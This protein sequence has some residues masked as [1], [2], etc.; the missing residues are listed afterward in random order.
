MFSPLS[1]LGSSESH[2]VLMFAQISQWTIV[3]LRL[4]HRHQMVM[5]DSLCGAHGPVARESVGVLFCDKRRLPTPGS[6]HDI[7]VHLPTVTITDTMN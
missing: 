3:R 7:S 4:R 6:E 1:E 5:V 2:G